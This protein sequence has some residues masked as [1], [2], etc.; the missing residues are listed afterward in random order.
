[1]LNTKLEFNEYCLIKFS[2]YSFEKEYKSLSLLNLF[3]SVSLELAKIN[4]ILFLC[5]LIFSRMTIKSSIFF[6][7]S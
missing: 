2:E 3:F 5:F 1:M 4:K 7:L 6:L